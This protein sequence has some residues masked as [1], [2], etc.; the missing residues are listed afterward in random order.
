MYMIHQFSTQRAL[1]YGVL[2]K[3]TMLSGMRRVPACILIPDPRRRN[4][5]NPPAQ[6]TNTIGEVFLRKGDLTDVDRKW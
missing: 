2:E 6:I 3:N 4:T 5:T 1:P